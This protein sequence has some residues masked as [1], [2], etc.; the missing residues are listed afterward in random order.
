MNKSQMILLLMKSETNAS[1]VISLLSPCFTGLLN[2]FMGTYFPQTNVDERSGNKKV[3]KALAEI[4][5]YIFLT[6]CSFNGTH[7]PPS[8]WVKPSADKN[9]TEPVSLAFKILNRLTN[10][11]CLVLLFTNITFMCLHCCGRVVA[12]FLSVVGSMVLL[13]VH[14]LPSLW[15]VNTA[16]PLIC[17]TVAASI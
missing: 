7:I 17:S 9:K 2:N 15:F 14:I 4:Y 12:T 3:V 10:R 16:I 11:L 1:S 6:D 5:D 8:L 13:K